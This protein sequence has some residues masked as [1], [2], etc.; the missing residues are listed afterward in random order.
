MT[1]KIFISSEQLEELQWNFPKIHDF[2]FKVTKKQDFTLS[3]ENKNLEQVTTTVKSW[4][5][6]KLS[7]ISNISILG[8]RQSFSRSSFLSF[9]NIKLQ[10]LSK[11]EED[12]SQD[13]LVFYFGNR[14]KLRTR[15]LCKFFIFLLKAYLDLWAF[16]SVTFLWCLQLKLQLLSKFE[17]KGPFPRFPSFRFW[18]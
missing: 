17:V 13:F 5:E 12:T 9:Q 10:L 2:I 14:V 16:A 4:I 1:E 11:F 7:K 3:L 18:V 6:R 8:T 15:N